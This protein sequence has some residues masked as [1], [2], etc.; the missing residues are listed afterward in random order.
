[1]EA[2]TE[3]LKQ[4]TINWADPDNGNYAIHIAA[5]NGHLHVAQLLIE[6]GADVNA[7]NANGLSAL[8]M[9]VSPLP[10]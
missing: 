10:P 5:Q 6:A 1:M 9:Y 7:K 8:H 2:V 3:L 4:G